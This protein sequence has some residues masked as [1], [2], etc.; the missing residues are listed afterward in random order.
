[1]NAVRK[2]G[3]RRG[4]AAF[5]FAAALCTL[6][7]FGVADAIAQ[8]STQQIA[9][10]RGVIALDRKE[11]EALFARSNAACRAVFQTTRCVNDA[12]AELRR[13]MAQIRQRGA[14][15]DQ[16][17]RRQR[18]ADQL[19]RIESKQNGPEAI[20]RAQA[21]EKRRLAA[22]EQAERQPS[23]PDVP[24]AAASAASSEPVEPQP[25]R[26]RAS[27]PKPAS[28]VESFRKKQAALLAHRQAVE[29]RNAA[30]DPA[31]AG[32][33]LPIPSAASSPA[34]ATRPAR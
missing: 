12:N 6:L 18:A 28:D 34:S 16:I 13:S 33:P 4:A 25:R 30:R 20:D 2:P 22:I 21:A 19:A 31:K 27:P 10:E 8:L 29:R 15:L 5:A 11:A 14:A 17:E 1:M 24:N 26:S 32:K 9:E 23:R 3:R 7:V